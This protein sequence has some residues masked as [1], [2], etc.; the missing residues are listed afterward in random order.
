MNYYKITCLTFH[1][2]NGKVEKT[3]DL[4]AENVD[5]ALKDLH[6][7]IMII[8]TLKIVENGNVL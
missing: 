4:V 5:E 8:Q 7:R 2:E 3:F 1:L 6:K